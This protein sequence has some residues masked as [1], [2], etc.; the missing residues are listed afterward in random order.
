MT[1]GCIVLPPNWV[2]HLGKDID[3]AG[4]VGLW[5]RMRDGLLLYPA[6]AV[7]I[8]IGAALMWWGLDWKK[9][10]KGKRVAARGKRGERRAERM[11]RRRGYR[12][13]SRQTAST[14]RI[15]VDGSS[16][17][18]TVKAD[19]IVRRWWRTWIA[20]VKTGDAAVRVEHEAT[21]RQLLE[22]Q[23]AFGISAILLVDGENGL[24]RE[25]RFPMRQRG[26]ACFF[27]VGAAVAGTVLGAA[28]VIAW[29]RPE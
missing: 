11:L 9:R 15:W 3:L 10:Y 27:V 24:I 8:G 14:Y 22:Y 5:L 26:R 1:W 28:A 17:A 13:I 2:A 7:A 4:G 19:L 29:I 25:V 16:V 6:L 23:L 20:E 18:T 12:I 21:R